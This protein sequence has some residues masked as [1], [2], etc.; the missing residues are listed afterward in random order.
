MHGPQPRHGVLRATGQPSPGRARRRHAVRRCHGGHR[1]GETIARRQSRLFSRQ[2]ARP[3]R[4]D[5]AQHRR[6]GQL[7]RGGAPLR[8]QPGRL[9]EL[10]GGQR[11]AAPSTATASLPRTISATATSNTRCTRSST[12]GRRRTTARNT[13]WRSPRSAPPTSP[14]R[15]RSSARWITSNALPSRRA[16][17]RSRSRTRTRCAARSMSTISPKYSPGYC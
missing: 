5:Q 6:H 9:R 13:A 10:A 4:R 14:A 2:R 3:A 16:A 17:R 8:G 12:N 7:L 1:C 11:R 15:T